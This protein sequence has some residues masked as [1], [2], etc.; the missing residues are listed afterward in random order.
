[1]HSLRRGDIGFP[2]AVVGAGAVCIVL[3]SFMA[4]AYGFV[5]SDGADGPDFDWSRMRDA[6]IEGGEY[7]LDIEGYLA[8]VCDGVHVRGISLDAYPGGVSGISPGHWE[9]GTCDGE[10]TRSVR[11]CIVPSD[12]GRRIPTTFTAVMWR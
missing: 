4:F 7:S 8:S 11:I 5:G 2:E 6:V 10:C 1:M 3:A 12:D 9:Y